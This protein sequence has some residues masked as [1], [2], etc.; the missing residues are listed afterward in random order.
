MTPGDL[1]KQIQANA[2][3]SASDSSTAL[4]NLQAFVSAA[5]AKQQARISQINTADLPAANTVLTDC[6][7]AT[8][9]DT[10]GATD[11]QKVITDLG[12]EV[13][14]LNA[15]IAALNALLPTS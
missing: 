14:S 12:N 4:G 3:Q 13:T 1:L 10:Q 9:P 11:A 7:N 8:P 5:V 6:N 2:T 15:S